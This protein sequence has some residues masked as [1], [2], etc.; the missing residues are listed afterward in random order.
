MH[1]DFK[2]GLIGQVGVEMKDLRKANR[3]SKS[4]RAHAERL[5]LLLLDEEVES[6]RKFTIAKIEEDV[7]KSAEFKGK[8]DE[9][10]KRFALRT[11]KA[12]EARRK[13][14]GT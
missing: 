11:H 10:K 4:D 12:L 5:S 8:S 3:L 14:R 13:K 9:F 2:N 6:G 7:N 1:Q